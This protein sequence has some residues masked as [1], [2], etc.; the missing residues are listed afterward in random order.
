MNKIIAAA[1]CIAA[2]ALPAAASDKD[3]PG[4][5][6]RPEHACSMKPAA[7]WMPIEQ[8]TAKLKEQGFT[9][10]KIEAKRAGCYEAKVTDAKGA[11]NRAS[12]GCRHRRDRQPPRS[13]LKCRLKNG[14]SRSA[15][16]YGRP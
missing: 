5:D 13:Q 15:G 6:A 16:V 12:S 7:E 9:V 3:R 4:H 11:G 2:M 8:I 10:L 1:A 14:R